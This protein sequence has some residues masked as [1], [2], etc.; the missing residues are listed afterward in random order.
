MS[1]SDLPPES[2]PEDSVALEP[3]PP[4]QVQRP[5]QTTARTIFQALVG[6]C[7]LFPILVAQA[8]LDP[9]T[10]PW[11]AIPLAVAATVARIMAIPAV[12][13]FLERFLP[14]LAAEGGNNA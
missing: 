10:L 9:E 14:F 12:N 5:W 2:Y 3:I 1:L 7:V 13:Q 8:G 4:T 11:L 6:L